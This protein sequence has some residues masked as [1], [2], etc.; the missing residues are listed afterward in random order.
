MQFYSSTTDDPAV[1]KCY[2]WA[3]IH[4]LFIDKILCFLKYICE[5]WISEI[6]VFISLVLFVLI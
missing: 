3:S 6:I 4:I 1:A 5:N 2:W